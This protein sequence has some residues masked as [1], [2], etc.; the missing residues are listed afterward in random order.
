MTKKSNLEAEKKPETKLNEVEKPIEKTKNSQSNLIKNNPK[1]ENSNFKKVIIGA[2]IL[3][4]IFL[5]V[6]LGIYLSKRNQKTK[7][8]DES[9]SSSSTQSSQSSS[10]SSTQSSQSSISSQKII[11]NID[12]VGLE[13]RNQLK[14]TQGLDMG[15][16]QSDYF[17]SLN[18][19]NPVKVSENKNLT[20][21]EF[22]KLNYPE[23]KRLQDLIIKPEKPEKTNWLSF[24]KYKVE[25]PVIYA[26]FQDMFVSDKDGIV[27]FSK[28][29]EEDTK[30]IAKGNYESVPVQKL[31][32]DGIVHLPFSTYPGEVGSSY[33]IGHSSNFSTVKSNYN[34]VF[35]P[36]EQ[37][38][39]VGDEFFI[40]DKDGRKLKFKVFEVKAIKEDDIEESYKNYQDRRV[41][42][43]QASILERV[44][45][46][47]QPTKRWLTRGELVIE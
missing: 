27:D 7:T 12:Y 44:N 19:K 45:G 35:A 32:K 17:K 2:L 26:S 22:K 5:M 29:I 36:I 46:V 38:S 40:Y 11:E 9:S 8:V 43:L 15:F 23:A 41:V 20:E 1:K 34:K 4:L 39:Q 37:K 42:T 10:S 25:A 14:S 30:E 3:A 21:E 33:I 31:L 16:I 47:L 6:S 28:P 24:P 13:V 18:M